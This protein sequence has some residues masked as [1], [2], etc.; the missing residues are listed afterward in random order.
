M[1]TDVATLENEVKE[2]KL[3]LESVQSSLQV[4]PDN[5]EL[6]SLKT[7]LEE[8]ISLTEQSIAELRPSVPEPPKGKPSHPPV[9]EKWSKENHPAYQA[10]YR[11]PAAETPPAEESQSSMVSFSVNDNVLARWA[12][13]D[14]AF[15]PARITSITGSSTN[16]IY[17]VSFKSYSTTETLTAKDIKPIS[18]NDTRKRKADG[19]SGTP[20]PQSLP[21]NSSVISAAADINPALA[22][23]ARTEGVKP[24]DGSRPAKVPR[25]VKGKR[26]LEAGKAKWQDFASKGKFGK[27]TKKESMFRTPEG[28]NARVGFTG[29][30]QQMR[31]DPT[32]SRHVYQQEEDTY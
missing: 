8:L 6:Q 13:G 12:S 9:K 27:A 18:N 20:G 31:K 21:A 1:S 29:S 4:D 30:G 22:S 14:N 19:I 11:K 2:F 23:K 26:D 24:A 3:Q 16:P 28:I 7:E 15:Y 17:I 25:K 32:R 10:G 5:T